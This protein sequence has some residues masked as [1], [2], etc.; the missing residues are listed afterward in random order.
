[1]RGDDEDFDGEIDGGFENTK[2]EDAAAGRGARGA[3]GAD[4]Q[5]EGDGNGS[6]GWGGGGRVRNYAMG[7][8]R[9]K[10][11]TSFRVSIGGYFQPC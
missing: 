3:T 8:R 10:R 4:G 6:N 7:G 1:M 2:G 5:A 11:M 9:R